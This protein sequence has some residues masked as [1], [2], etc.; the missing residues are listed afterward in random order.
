ME[1]RSTLL[2]AALLLCIAAFGQAIDTLQLSRSIDENDADAVY[3]LPMLQEMPE[4]PGGMEALYRYLGENIHYPDLAVQEGAEG[5]VFV[6]FVIGKD[7]TIQDVQVIRGV[8]PD[9]DAEA[10][11]GVQEMPAWSP[12]R[13]DGERVKVRF[14]LPVSFKL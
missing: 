5:K 12:G 4:F 13:L 1:R 7:G 8:R 11:R 6:Q 2:V 3:E 10:M 9:L 14:T